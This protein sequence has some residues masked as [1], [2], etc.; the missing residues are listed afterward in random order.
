MTPDGLEFSTED[1]AYLGVQCDS[2][3][4]QD[5]DHM[6]NM[7]QLF[8]Y[9]ALCV[10]GLATLLAW[11]ISVFIPPTTFTWRT[12]SVLSAC[13]AVIGVPIFLIFES[14][15]CAMDINR[16]TCSVATGGY[17]NIVSITLYVGMTL[18][19]QCLLPPDWTKETKAWRNTNRE[20]KVGEITIPS[21]GESHESNGTEDETAPHEAAPS[22]PPP[23]M[24]WGGERQYGQPS[25][26]EKLN[27]MESRRL[28]DKYLGEEP[29]EVDHLVFDLS[30]TKTNLDEIEGFT[31]VEDQMQDAEEPEHHRQE[32]TRSSFW[33]LKR[34][35]SVTKE[36]ELAV[37][38][39]PEAKRI[40]DDLEAPEISIES[41]EEENIAPE[42]L[43]A[44][45]ALESVEA[46]NHEENQ[47]PAKSDSG[48]DRGS[49]NSDQAPKRPSF[50]SLHRSRNEEQDDNASVP[51]PVYTIP[52]SW[53]A[54]DIEIPP[55]GEVSHE[56]NTD[57]NDALNHPHEAKMRSVH[58]RQGAAVVMA[59][60]KGT[61]HALAEKV[62]KV[63]HRESPKTKSK[64]LKFTI[65][66]PDGVE[67]RR[68]L[69]QQQPSEEKVVEQ[70]EAVERP[71]EELEKPY[72]ERVE[73]IASRKGA[74]DVVVTHSI[75]RRHASVPMEREDEIVK[76]TSLNTQKRVQSSPVQFTPSAPRQNRDTPPETLS[77]HTPSQTVS[78]DDVSEI[79][80]VPVLQKEI[81]DE[82]LAILADLARFE[83]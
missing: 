71:V 80:P 68:K 47:M 65:I 33:T 32:R 10:G 4:Y 20:V 41:V 14:E 57:D 73:E 18:W 26:L 22:S 5:S 43:V 28:E 62:R 81:P 78:F 12:L 53:D 3:F 13:A 29:E 52:L 44:N 49:S 63:S 50:W 75:P 69:G 55:P 54:E 1:P 39:N 34:N 16:Q 79:T 15:P 21:G 17:L 24:N 38:E 46:M 82:T 6:W 42:S 31:G 25:P 7:S 8:L 51:R 67:E 60:L 19:T 11:V 48:K 58:M 64:G 36:E 27:S 61:T 66:G 83:Q 30:Y 2:P 9:I 76:S 23:L 72:S 37:A 56:E 45:F 40:I 74:R 77:L 59:S 70:T 35:R